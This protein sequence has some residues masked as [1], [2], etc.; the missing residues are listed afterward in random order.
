M[1]AYHRHTNKCKLTLLLN[2]Q[3]NSGGCSGE[4]CNA[5]DKGESTFIKARLSKR[6]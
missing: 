1:T 2:L 6:V 3:D 5:E 4:P